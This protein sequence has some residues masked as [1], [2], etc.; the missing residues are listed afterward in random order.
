MNEHGFVKSFHSKLSKRIYKWK[1]LD[2]M[3]GGIPDGWYCGDKNQCFI[4]F[5][6]LDRL[7]KNP[8]QEID[9]GLSKLQIKWI[10]DRVRQ[11][12]H[13]FVIASV[14]NYKYC[15]YI[16]PNNI[17]RNQSWYKPKLSS[18]II[19]NTNEAIA[20]LERFLLDK[21]CHS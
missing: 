19:I 6:F 2:T 20:D 18:T 17:K 12:V 7:P 15:L 16:S 13:V 14:E 8:E 4:E 3:V 10:T 5:K 9:L 21:G 11:N 1:I